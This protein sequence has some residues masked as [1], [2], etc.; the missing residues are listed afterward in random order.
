MTPLTIAPIPTCQDIPSVFQSSKPMATST[1]LD[2]GRGWRFPTLGPGLGWLERWLYLQTLRSARQERLLANS[3]ATARH[4]RLSFMC[5]RD[6]QDGK[7]RTRSQAR[8]A[9][10]G[11][12]IFH[13]TCS[14]AK[15]KSTRRARKMLESPR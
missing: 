15:K 4:S 6:S 1:P 7:T 9:R 8:Q 5:H 11:R 2:T 13:R 12:R 3:R 10:P 14:P